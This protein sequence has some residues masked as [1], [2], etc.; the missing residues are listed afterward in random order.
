MTIARR[1]YLYLIA[2]VALGMLVTG[3]TGILELGIESAVERLIPSPVSVGSAD[4]RGRLSFSV[5]VTAIGLIA[6]VLHWWIAQR[7]VRGDDVGHDERRSVIRA[8]FVNAVLLVGSLIALFAA[9]EFI[10]DVAGVPLGVVTAT[11][12][13]AGRMSSP[14]SLF[15]VTALFLLYH[16]RIG[17][18]DRS[19]APERRGGATLRRWF[20]YVMAFVA[21]LLF[22]FAMAGLIASIWDEI[23]VT[24]G[25]VVIGTSGLAFEV[26]GRIGSIAAGAIAWLAAWRW[27]SGWISAPAVTDSPAGSESRSILRKVYVY[28]ILAVSVTWTIWNLGQIL[29]GLMRTFLLGPGAVGGWLSV[30][31]RVG[32]PLAAAGVFGVCWLYHARIVEFEAAAIAEERRQA[33]IRWIYGYLV[34]LVAIVMFAIGIG[35]A[36]ATGLDLIAQPGVV[37]P[38]EWWAD[39]I[40]VFATL[41]V[42]AVPLWYGFWSRLQSEAAGPIARESIARRVYLFVAIA[43]SVLT[44]LMSGAYSLYQFVRFALGERW[45][46]GQTSELIAAACAAAVAGLLLTYHLRVLRQDASNRP[47][48]GADAGVHALVFL[49]A[50]DSSAIDAAGSALRSI[51]G[52]GVDIVP[53]DSMTVGKLRRDTLHLEEST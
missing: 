27:S 24:P 12:A 30:L 25:A 48:P 18:F 46:S 45:T 39:R 33:A 16:I 11:D 4:P 20:A 52:L 31:D 5:A 15:T 17:S 53:V 8:L 28:L 23:I 49:R 43:L 26:A 7:Y 6:W 3:L 19:V 13:I 34:S 1:V 21:L 14:G 41:A 38:T 32:T 36:A 29:Y 51:A 10:A 9:R 2:F 35:G 42:V 40:S 37:R 22:A 47:V 50:G 44:L